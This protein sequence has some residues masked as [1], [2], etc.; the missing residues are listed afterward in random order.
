MGWGDAWW[1]GAVPS[2]T[3]RIALAPF[4]LMGSWAPACLL[5]FMRFWSAAFFSRRLCLLY[6]EG[7]TPLERAPRLALHVPFAAKEEGGKDGC[8][9]FL[10]QSSCASGGFPVRY[11]R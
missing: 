9:R 10:A 7:Y 4:A 2:L 5:E 1:V 3:Q 6:C 8:F 11:V